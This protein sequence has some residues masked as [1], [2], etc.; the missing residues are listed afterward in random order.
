VLL[1]AL[2]LTPLPTADKSG[3]APQP[4]NA[5]ELVNS[6][7]LHTTAFFNNCIVCLN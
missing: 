1:V 4:A 3:L 2:R 6:T 7:A 5:H